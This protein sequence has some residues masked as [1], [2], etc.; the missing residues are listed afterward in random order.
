MPEVNI[1]T[2]NRKKDEARAKEKI[3]EKENNTLNIIAMPVLLAI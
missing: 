3:K 1:K 2:R